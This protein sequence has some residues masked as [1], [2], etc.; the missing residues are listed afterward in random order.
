MKRMRSRFL[1]LAYIALMAVV[2]LI[3]CTSKED[4]AET[5][6]VCGNHAC[7]EL[8]MVTADTSS[9]GYHYLE[10][11]VSPSGGQILFTADWVAL[12]AESR[13]NED[14]F[15][16]NYRQMLIIPLVGRLDPETSLVD[17]GARLLRLVDRNIPQF[18]V[19]GEFLEEAV[20]I[21]KADP[22]WEDDSHIIFRLELSR[23]Y[24][25]FRA[26]ISNP[27]AC[28][29]EPLFL[30]E[31]D[32]AP[33]GRLYQHF[34]P[35]LSPDGRWL[36]FTRFSC[37]IPDSLE[38]CTQITLTVLDMDTAGDDNGYEAVTFPV[39]NEY[40]RI[41][42]PAWSPDGSKLV[43]S[44]G[45]DIVGQSDWGTE[46]YTI[47]FDTTGLA[48]GEMV[49]DNNLD[50]LT[51]TGYSDGDPIVGVFNTSP[52]YSN[53]GN[54]IF[55]VSTRRM[56]TTTHHDRN[57]WVIPADGSLDP[58]IYF[59]TRSDD[60]DGSMLPD[61]SMLVSSQLGFTTELLNRAEEESYQRARQLQPF[62]NDL[63]MRN[64]AAEDRHTLELF[65]DVMSH[66]YVYRK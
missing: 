21:R 40:S 7:G 45:F 8:V 15:F 16:T 20:N 17:Q 53:S 5:L 29:F 42:E 19:D 6:A 23:G 26:E 65:E 54:E 30:E 31:E 2:A 10:P 57:I 38:T 50:R 3:G 59:Y 66:L 61:G 12:P 39:T 62:L 36:A 4:P 60:V 25:L 28:T 22:L 49:L 37:S 32:R 33:F 9:D 11:Q 63:E 24:R 64:V 1:P 27:D 34:E 13:Y 41:E 44:A 51:F 47:D 14:D 43:F 56:P 46:L 48:E 18:T 52:F 55:F 58:E 35:A